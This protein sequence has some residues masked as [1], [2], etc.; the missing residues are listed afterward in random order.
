MWPQF[1]SGFCCDAQT[2]RRAR[3]S[4]SGSG[5]GSQAL[6]VGRHRASANN[7]GWPLG[8]V[9]FVLV[10]LART[11]AFVSMWPIGLVRRGLDIRGQL[12]SVC[13]RA[14]A[15][16]R[17]LHI[18]RTQRRPESDTVARSRVF[19]LASKRVCVDALSWLPAREP[20]ESVAG[21]R[22]QTQRRRQK[23]VRLKCRCFLLARSA[24][25]RRAPSVEAKA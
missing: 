21:S 10:M 4:G 7:C 19:A 24:N 16:S 23:H 1:V 13:S 5:S 8:L 25:Q 20:R 11:A 6:L 18:E 15:L 9:A 12:A 22:L 17:C 14:L 3:V 2:G